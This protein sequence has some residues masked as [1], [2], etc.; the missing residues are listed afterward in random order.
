MDG[1]WIFQNFGALRSHEERTSEAHNQQ[2]ESQL[3]HG[4]LPS[5]EAKWAGGTLTEIVGFRT[6]SKAAKLRLSCVAACKAC[7]APAAD[8]ELGFAYAV[9]EHD[10]LVAQSVPGKQYLGL[11]D[12]DKQA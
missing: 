5:I 7:K 3:R 8:L 6:P 4:E 1:L 9:E 10:L 2:T 12:V 11:D